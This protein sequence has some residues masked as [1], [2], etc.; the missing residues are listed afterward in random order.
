MHYQFTARQ[1]DELEGATNELHA[2]CLDAAQHVIDGDR[3]AEFGI[4]PFAVPAI[5]WA[6]N[7]EP[8]A[9]YGRFDLAYDGR[10]PPKL[11]EYNADTPTGLIEAAIA[12]WYWKEDVLKGSDQFNSIHERLVAKWRELKDY[13]TGER[14]YFAATPE[15]QA[16]DLMTATYM[17]DTATAAGLETAALM[18]GDIGWN[19]QGFVDLEDRPVQ[20]IFKFIPMGV[21]ALGG[22]R[23]ARGQHH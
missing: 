17:R 11:L 20:S 7:A 19:G 12:Q 13:L 10:T 14:L 4:P 23:P 22:V 2:R 15:Q 8:P 6:W 3:F 9:I 16:E 5:K 21:D 1:I 18:V